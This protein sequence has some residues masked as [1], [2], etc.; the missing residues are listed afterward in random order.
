MG[1]VRH[2]DDEP[3]DPTTNAPKYNKYG[4]IMQQLFDHK[5]GLKTNI[6]GGIGWDNVAG[7]VWSLKKAGGPIRRR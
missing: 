5:Y 3:A 7:I 6:G 4:G 2:D 1:D